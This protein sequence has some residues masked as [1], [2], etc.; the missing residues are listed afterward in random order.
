MTTYYKIRYKDNPEMYIKGTPAYQSSD[1]TG[2]MFASLGQ[3]RTFLTGVMN[4]DTWYSKMDESHR[5]RV[6]NW[7]VVEYELTEKE[8][9]GIH[10]V[11]TAKKLKELLMK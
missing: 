8:V 9:K 7:E 10:E 5:N 1:K 11:I 3:L 6:A 4:N 2:R